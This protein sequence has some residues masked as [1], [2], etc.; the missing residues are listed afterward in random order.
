MPCFAPV[1]D[2]VIRLHIFYHRVS[3][4]SV[5]NGFRCDG[6]KTSPVADPHLGSDD[7]VDGHHHTLF[8]YALCYCKQ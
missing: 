5:M 8:K 2:T 3:F 6:Q 1:G 7:C 4:G